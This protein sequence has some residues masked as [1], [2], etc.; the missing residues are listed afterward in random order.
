M[1]TI[2][3]KAYRFNELRKGAKKAAIDHCR[4]STGYL[5]YEWWDSTYEDIATQMQEEGFDIYK[6][7]KYR[8]HKGEDKTRED[9][10]LSFDLCA[11]YTA[12]ADIDVQSIDVDKM[13]IPEWITLKTK[14]ALM[15][16]EDEVDINFIEENSTIEVEDNYHAGAPEEDEEMITKVCE[17]IQERYDAWRKKAWKQ[18]DE[19]YDY[20]NSDEAISEHLI[21]NGYEYTWKGERI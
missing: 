16:Q 7:V 10:Q 9:P 19:E 18:L 11:G 8:T 4:E 5:D 20:L 14:W 21:A 17:I 12:K 1:R 15:E 2:T 6:T 3:T 13:N